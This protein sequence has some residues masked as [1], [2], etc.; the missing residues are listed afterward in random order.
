MVYQIQ[1]GAGLSKMPHAGVGRCNVAAFVVGGSSEGR[2]T[3]GRR[4]S[5]A[6]CCAVP[7][8]AAQGGKAGPGPRL[9]G[10]LGPGQEVAHGRLETSGVG[11]LQAAVAG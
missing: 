10:P 1:L 2:Q 3:A 4:R 9:A 11:H 8:R 7:C 5:V 6:L